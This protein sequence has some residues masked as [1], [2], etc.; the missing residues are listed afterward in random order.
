MD[1]DLLSVMRLRAKS[2]MEAGFVTDEVV[3]SHL[4]EDSDGVGLLWP[5]PV[6]AAGW[7]LPS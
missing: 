2:T 6:G 5:E 3:E 4:Q 7:E 1:T